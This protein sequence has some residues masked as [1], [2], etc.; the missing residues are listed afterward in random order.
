MKKILCLG[1][2]QHALG[3]ETALDPLGDLKVPPTPPKY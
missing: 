1:L 3:V 2:P